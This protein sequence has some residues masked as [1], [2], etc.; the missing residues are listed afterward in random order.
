MLPVVGQFEDEIRCGRL[1]SERAVISTPTL[2]PQRDLWRW[3]ITS[4][5]AVVIASS[6]LS[7]SPLQ[8]QH[9]RP[10]PS[11]QL[12]TPIDERAFANECRL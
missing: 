12:A 9:H 10:S 5:A 3:L 8:Q 6:L 11:H 7:P 2:T 4:I 1:E